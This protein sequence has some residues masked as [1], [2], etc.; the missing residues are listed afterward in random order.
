ML[1][2]PEY[3]DRGVFIWLM[4]AAGIGYVGS[5]LGYG[6]TAARC[7]QI[8]TPLFAVVTSA[9]ALV[10]FWLIPSGGLRGAAIGLLVAGVL[11]AGGS[12]AIVLRL[13]HTSV[14]PN[15]DTRYAQE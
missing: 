13:L 15:K 6:I 2:R 7:F 14:M 11:Q 8:Q 9:T 3:A 10:C 5:F 12:L 1:Y 4:L